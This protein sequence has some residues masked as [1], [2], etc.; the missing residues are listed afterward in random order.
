MSGQVGPEGTSGKQNTDHS[1]RLEYEIQVCGTLW[2]L[3][4]WP[5]SPGGGVGLGWSV[6]LAAGGDLEAEQKKAISASIRWAL[7]C[8]SFVAPTQVDP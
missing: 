6:R 2:P 1:G 5:H 8:L 3:P 4:P 7:L